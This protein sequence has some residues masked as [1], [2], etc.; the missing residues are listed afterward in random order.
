MATGYMCDQGWH[1]ADA[2]NPKLGENVLAVVHSY[3]DDSQKQVCGW[4][5][6]QGRWRLGET[7][8]ILVGGKITHWMRLP[9]FPLTFSYGFP[10]DYPMQDAA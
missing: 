8:E 10:I 1:L 2:I 5:D 6:A 9:E 3:I 4:I 7:G